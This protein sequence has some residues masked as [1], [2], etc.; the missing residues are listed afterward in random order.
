MQRQSI[1]ANSKP[2]WSRYQESTLGQSQIE[3]ILLE[4]VQQSPH[5]QVRQE[6]MPVS[7]DIDE[8]IIER[9]DEHSYPLRVKLMP[10]AGA[11]AVNNP[12]GESV[13][14]SNGDVI[15]AKYLLGC[16]G[17]HSWIRKQL[18]LKLEGASRDVSWGVLDTFPL[19]DF[20]AFPSH[21]SS[22]T[23]HIWLIGQT[24]SGHPST[25]HCKI[26][27]WKSDDHSARAQARPILCPGV[28]RTR[29]HVLGERWEPRSHY[30]GCSKDHAV[31]SV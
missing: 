22:Q 24:D 13:P 16:D 15:E 5:V 25:M 8:S 29:Q 3:T 30:E 26:R 6:T 7:L 10:V 27:I 19:T 18:G 14:Q 1:S 12:N 4:L 28:I 11:N 2:G 21:S 17:A 9:H 23:R 20:R 31:V